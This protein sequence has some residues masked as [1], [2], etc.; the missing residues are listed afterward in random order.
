VSNHRVAS[1][2]PGAAGEM[3]LCDGYPFAYTSHVTAVMI[4][5]QVVS[6]IVR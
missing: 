2:E 3:A 6:E 5:G 4:E 1:L